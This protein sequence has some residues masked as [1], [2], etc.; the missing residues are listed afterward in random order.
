MTLCRLLFAATPPAKCPCRHGEGKLS[1]VLATL[2]VRCLPAA[3]LITYPSRPLS[4][5]FIRPRASPTRRP[6]DGAAVITAMRCLPMR[7]AEREGATLSRSPSNCNNHKDIKT[8]NCC[9]KRSFGAEAFSP[10]RLWF[11]K[12]FSGFLPARKTPKT[13]CQLFPEPDAL[14]LRIYYVALGGQ[15]ITLRPI[16]GIRNTRGRGSRVCAFCLPSWPSKCATPDSQ[17]H[18]C[19]RYLPKNQQTHFQND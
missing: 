7:C 10:A 11:P 4:S 13:G 17:T 19:A 16:P 1:E 3:R 9:W 8:V 12:N 2:S 6:W 5:R 15:R 18:S 14:S